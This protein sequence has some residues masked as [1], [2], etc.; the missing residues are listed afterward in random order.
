MDEPTTA[1]YEMAVKFLLYHMPRE[2]RRK[3]MNELPGA[4]NRIHG[5]NIVKVVRTSDNTSI[6]A[7]D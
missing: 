7:G 5:Y 4:Y 2:L 1:D 6:V 3:F